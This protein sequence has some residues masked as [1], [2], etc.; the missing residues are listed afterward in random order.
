MATIY[1][2]QMIKCNLCGMEFDVE[3][4]SYVNRLG[5]HEEWHSKPLSES[6][7]SNRITGQVEWIQIED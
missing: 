3:D 4:D 2:S 1:G 6:A 7:S 5:R